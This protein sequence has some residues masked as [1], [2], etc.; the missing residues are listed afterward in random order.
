MY[1]YKRQHRHSHL[2]NSPRID[3]FAFYGVFSIL[4]TII[5][6][7]LQGH[8]IGE[9]KQLLVENVYHLCIEFI[10]CIIKTLDKRLFLWYLYISIL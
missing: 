7:K 5:S 10:Q 3:L 1:A 6:E 2:D 4:H 9:N 8:L